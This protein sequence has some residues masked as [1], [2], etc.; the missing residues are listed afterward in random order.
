MDPSTE[1]AVQ[2]VCWN[3]NGLTSC[4]R[5]FG[6]L[7]A[8]LSQL[9]A[10]ILCMQEVKLTRRSLT[11]DLGRCPGYHALFSLCKTKGYSG[12]ATFVRESSV[13]TLA[14]ANGIA[15]DAFFGGPL[16]MSTDVSSAR[17]AEMDAEG[18]CV[19]T[20]HGAFTLFN[21]YAPC[22]Y[23]DDEPK[24]VERRQFKEDFQRTLTARCM[25]L[26]Q[27]GKHV[28]LVGD[29]NACSSP[30]DHS[31]TVPPETF[32]TSRWSTWLRGLLGLPTG[33]AAVALAAD[34]LRRQA[35]TSSSSS[36]SNINCVTDTAAAGDGNSSTD[37]VISESIPSSSAMFVD[38]Y[39]VTNP[40]TEKAFTCWS[41]LKSARCNNYGSRIDYIL[42]D[43]ELAASS[44]ILSD[45]WPHVHGSDHCPVIA[46]LR[47]QQEQQQC[48]SSDSA[49]VT[50]ANNDNT[51]AVSTAVAPHP[52]QCSCFYPELGGNVGR[53]TSYFSVRSA[54]ANTD[55]DIGDDADVSMTSEVQRS[56]SF[57]PFG[58]ACSS[59]SSSSGDS[60]HN[61]A[62][63]TPHMQPHS[64]SSSSTTAMPQLNRSSSNNSS[65]GGVKV[66]SKAIA[67]KSTV[68]AA[69]KPDKKRGLT[70]SKLSMFTI[71]NKA[72]RTSPTAVANSSGSCTV[73]HTSATDISKQQQHAFFGSSSSSSNVNNCSS[74]SSSSSG[75]TGV[76]A[77][78]AWKALLSRPQAPLCSGH[79]E[80]AVE[81]TVLKSG[82]NQGRR[83]WC[84]TRGQ[85]DWP[86]DKQARCEYFVWRG[87]G[88]LG[89]MVDVKARQ[90]QGV[91]KK[92]A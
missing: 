44:L 79:Q 16:P 87:D 19:V 54:A 22:V 43:P 71:A 84:C 12:V 49:A 78:G 62:T 83:F 28:V 36:S 86:T 5:S 27:R 33:A 89:Y 60:S 77:A 75:S 52:P 14:A 1:K 45:V 82:P 69:A 51:T 37:A 73:Q 11:Y 81:R 63:D 13:A 74:S 76:A 17:L 30:I 55:D 8:M 38:C 31:F 68:A 10:D 15:D 46:Q 32:Y 92:R 6:D 2:L 29:L 53:L 7:P 91:A 24:S 26:R 25:Q 72:Q 48:D 21:V 39:R 4:V 90:Q 47:I 61:A 56:D 64:S 88:V 66:V 41:M 20:D 40:T 58:L 3:V 9:G 65:S 57:D 18:R 35:S 34:A 67:A 80:P 23:G 70:Q 42:A 50:D 59:S 85:G